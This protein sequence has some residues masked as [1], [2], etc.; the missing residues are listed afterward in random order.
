MG[1][2][3]L[4]AALLYGYGAPGFEGRPDALDRPLRDFHRSVDV[5]LADGRR[6]LVTLDD[7]RT[8]R[9]LA[10]ALRPLGNAL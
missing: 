10:T 4:L 2:I 8:M 7:F 1:R 9:Y 5:A 3:V 6:A